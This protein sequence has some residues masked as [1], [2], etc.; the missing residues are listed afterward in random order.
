MYTYLHG[1][2][3]ATR[4]QSEDTQSL[5]DNHPLLLI[6]RR[7]NTLKELETLQSSST[8]SSL[9]GDHTAN[10]PVEN[11]GGCAVVE[12]A[13]FF[14]VDNVAFVEEVVVAQLRNQCKSSCEM[15]PN[16]VNWY[17]THLVTEEAARDVD[18]LAP[19]NDNLLA[20]QNLLGDNRGQPAKKMALAINDDGA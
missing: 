2:V 11:L 9:V 17:V 12:G 20:V 16:S 13:G 5:R 19:H 6:V 18:L 1:A 7:G 10:G 4:L 14:G 8:A 15:R 3:L